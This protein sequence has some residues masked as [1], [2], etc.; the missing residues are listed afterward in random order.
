M[1]DGKT[2]V[3]R[4]RA[5]VGQ[6]RSFDGGSPQSVDGVCICGACRDCR[7]ALKDGEMGRAS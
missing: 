2:P 6:V 5:V 7:L 3:K 4:L 1:S